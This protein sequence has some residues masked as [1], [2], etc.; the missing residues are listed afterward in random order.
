[1][2]EVAQVSS[3]SGGCMFISNIVWISFLK[4]STNSSTLQVND[5]FKKLVEIH[6]AQAV[7]VRNLHKEENKSNASTMQNI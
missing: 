6:E 7:E 1:M 3:Q 5:N 2:T 4:P